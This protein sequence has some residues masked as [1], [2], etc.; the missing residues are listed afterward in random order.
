MPEGMLF[1]L[2]MEVGR[3]DVGIGPYSVISG[4]VGARIARPC[5][6]AEW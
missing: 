6:V 2:C 4:R 5:R 1:F 3:A